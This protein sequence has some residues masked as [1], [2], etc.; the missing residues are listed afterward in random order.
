[1]T[2]A[3]NELKSDRL[4]SFGAPE[5]DLKPLFEIIG[6]LRLTLEECRDL[7]ND[8][9]KFPQKNGVITNI[10]YNIDVD[11][12][13]ISL[14]ERIA[15]HNNKISLVLDPFKLHLQAQLSTLHKETHQDVAEMFQELRQ[16]IASG[17]QPAPPKRDVEVPNEIAKKF[18]AVCTP[19]VP[20]AKEGNRPFPSFPLKDG[21]EAFFYHFNGI[22]LISDS[23]SYLRLL[24][25]IWVMDRLR[26]S[27]EW[28]KIQ[29]SNPGGLYDRCIRE[30]DR[31]LRQECSRV[32]PGQAPLPS[33][34]LQL[35]EDTFS[36]WPPVITGMKPTGTPHLGVLL[37]IPILPDPDSHSLRI[38]RNIDGTLGL[39][40][41]TV[42]TRE[43]AGSLSSESRIQTLN[44]EPKSAYFVPI[45]AIPVA[46]GSHSASL[47]VK[48]QSSRDGVNGIA[49]ELQSESDLLRLQ[50]LITGYKCLKQRSRITVRSLTKGQEFPSVHSTGG[51]RARIPEE[52]QEFGNLQF[53]QHVSY[54]NSSSAGTGSGS[55]GTRDIKDRRA[56]G[57]SQATGIKSIGS[58]MSFS[59]LGSMSSAHAQQ[60]TLGPSA[61]G[62]LLKEPEPYFLVLF[63]KEM[64]HGVL[65]F[66][67]V[68]LDE[69]THINPIAC[70][71]GLKK[72]CNASVLERGGKPLLARRFYARAGLNSWNLAAL[73]EH[74]PA[75]E[76]GAVTVQ[77]MYW[78][79]VTFRKESER[80]KF[81]AD[82][83]KLVAMYAGRMD[84]YMRD[85]KRVRATHI[86]SKR[87]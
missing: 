23:M 33:L 72:R 77:E 10:M 34:L 49:P 11:P 42:T 71:C 17:S 45:Y 38:V 76:N 78:L 46:T 16:L 75:R 74:W 86:L 41:T 27:D 85:L 55:E 28:Y 25:S 22:S 2:R 36:I 68:E 7:M 43:T 87:G 39:E 59:T 5:Y 51:R 13:V 21:L 32:D 48:L 56:S 66:L 52:L 61:T 67:V 29:N 4:G 3:N 40:D 54:E 79:R 14:T 58:S 69:N 6:N 60:V 65:S 15:F 70:E 35:P 84:D 31:K 19:R 62:I 47:T 26:E 18:A 53:W 24:K 81:N 1:M 83:G 64:E 50:H 82:V 63:L 44:I 73:G 57:I 20:I 12:Y 37:D 9:S 80:V 30:M 8:E